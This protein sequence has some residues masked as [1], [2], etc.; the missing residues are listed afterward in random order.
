MTSTQQIA[1]WADALRDISALGLYFTESKYDLERYQAIQDVSIQ[2]LAAA[3][4][5]PEG[6]FE[7]LRA[8][9]F[10][11]PTPFS[12]GDAA[13]IDDDG[14]ILLVQRADNTK[15]A[16]PGGALQVGET[17]AEGVVRE[18]LEETGCRCEPQKLVGVFDSR[19]CGSTTRHHLYQFVFL[20]KPLN[21][22]KFVPAT[23]PHEVI[24]VGWFSRENLPHEIDPGHIS[25]ISA[26]Y[27]AW[28]DPSFVY[29]DK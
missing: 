16:M 22:D 18:A 7:P 3:V 1:I 13:I 17:P 6:S 27:Q 21:R 4:D 19:Y 8:S 9:V 5:E 10:S 12:T 24:D 14:C 2:M 28:Q 15:W 29:F 25:R 20:C 23:H 26:A 11:R